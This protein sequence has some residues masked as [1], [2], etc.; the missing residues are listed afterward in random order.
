MTTSSTTTLGAFVAELHL[1]DVPD[2][3]LETAR[4]A[5]A[6][7]LCVAAAGGPMAEVA[8]QWASARPG[9]RG[10]HAFLSGRPLTPSDAAFVNACLMHA[11][12]QD[13]TYFPGLTHV[14]SAT[15]PAVLAMAESRELGLREVL[16]GIVAGY[17]VAAAISRVGAAT[18]TTQGFRGSGIYGVFGAAAGVSR[19][20]GLDGEACGHALAIAAS[21]ASGTNQTW[22]DGSLEWQLQ[23]G[24]ASRSGLEAALLAQSGATGS[25]G[26][27]EGAS[28]FFTAFARDASLAD[29]LAA[30]IGQ[31]WATRQVTF[32][33]HPVCA[34]LQ[35]A[36]DA[37]AALANP[38]SQLC[39]ATLRLTASEAGY[40]GTDGVPPFADAGAALMSASYCVSTALTRG[41]VTVDDLLR[42][43]EPDRI[44]AARRV[45][46]VADPA[47]GPRE[48]ILDAVW[49]DGR[50]DTVG[51]HQDLATWTRHQLDANVARL[52][53]EVPAGLDLSHLVDQV[54]GSMDLP[55][56][57]LVGVLMAP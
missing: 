47:L 15:T 19:V 31:T 2:D 33:A 26:A 3:V 1:G 36:V 46:V 52:Q 10:S 43:A 14:G 6:H 30:D 18:T 21:M 44:T 57:D 53:A 13:D 4:I 25:V 42:S 51:G 37:A 34:I 8:T 56:T 9:G 7:N 12:A 48:F 24:T 5:L 29:D 22:I 35:A 45:T 23:L 20:L 54:F 11:R 27:L 39:A 50:R 16:L 49:A 41:G 38:R 55:A 40:P 17:E 32:K 28:G